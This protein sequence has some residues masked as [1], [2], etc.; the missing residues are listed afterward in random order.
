MSAVSFG[1]IPAASNTVSGVVTVADQIFKGAKTIVND[2]N[3]DGV[4]L[5]G[6]AGG[7]SG[8]T[9]NLTPTTLTASVTVTLP[10]TGG[11]LNVGNTTTSSDKIFLSTS[12][13][14][15]GVWSTTSIGTMAYQPNTG[16]TSITT[17]GTIGTGTWAASVI[18]STYGGTGVNNGGRTLTIN[19]N[20]G[21]ITF[22][23]ASKTLT[24][25]ES[26]TLTALTNGDILYASSTNTVGSTG[27]VPVTKGGTGLTVL[28]TANQILR[29]NAG[30]TALEYF[31][32]T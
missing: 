25:N 29:V 6:R 19:T 22:G 8:H 28:G 20:S 5:S 27:S 11:T 10:N 23:A 14:G 13:A 21:T 24:I 12:T 26:I 15:L 30:T 2:T 16:T 31:T 18:S 3:Q 7:T 9:V 1:S 4:K 17:L 32:P